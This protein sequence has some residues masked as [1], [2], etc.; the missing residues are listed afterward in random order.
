MIV[1]KPDIKYDGLKKLSSNLRNKAQKKAMVLASRELGKIAQQIIETVKGGNWGLPKYA[2]EEVNGM[3]VSKPIVA[4]NSVY[5]SIRWPSG[6]GS[7]YEF[8]TT[9]KKWIIKPSGI[10]QHGKA[11]KSLRWETRGGG[12]AYAKKVT[13]YW[14]PKHLKPHVGPAIE[15]VS[16]YITHKFADIAAEAIEHA[17]SGIK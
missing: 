14:T 15:K 1:V 2:T 12:V 17:M 4:G 8:G 9:K 6:I 5:R 10:N 11:V 13:H 3:D 7:Y 16:P